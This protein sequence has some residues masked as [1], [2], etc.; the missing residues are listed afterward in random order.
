MTV[1]NIIEL[2]ADYLEKKGVESS[3]LNAE[4]LLAKVLNCKRMDL[5]LHFDQPLKKSEIDKYRQLLKRRGQR[6][7]LQYII[8]ESEFYG[9]KFLVNH[10]VLIPRQETEILVETIIY[11][12]KNEGIKILDVGTGSGNI[13]ITLAKEIMNAHITTIDVNKESIEVAKKNGS[14]NNLNGEIDFKNIP[15]EEFSSSESFNI[16]VSNP[17]YVSSDE[18]DNLDPELKNY[19]PKNALTDEKDGYYFYRL[20]IKK[21]QQ[22]LLPNGKIYFEIGKGQSEKVK[23]LLEKSDFD[24]INIVKDYQN[25][26]RVIYGTIK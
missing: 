15:I 19:E 23:S 26:D 2:S 13:A 4:L 20:I 21:A 14:I 17:P 24:N 12:H 9:Y 3:R 18:Y 25:I 10:N 5:Y 16:I 22:L 1:L 11:N 7:P 8:G 6:E